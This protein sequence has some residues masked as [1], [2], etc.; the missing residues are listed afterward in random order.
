MARPHKQTVDYFPHF[1]NSKKTLL[2]MESRWG[3][4]G[5]AFWFKM[6]EMLCS[7]EGH[8]IDADN[9]ADLEYIIGRCRITEDA[10]IE[11]LDVLARVGAI[12][13]ELWAD[14]RLIWCQNLVDNLSDLYRKRT[15]PAPS[16]PSF[17]R[18]KP[19]DC[20]ISDADKTPET[21]KV[22]ESKPKES[23]S[24]KSKAATEVFGV[25]LPGWKMERKA[26]EVWGVNL[27]ARFPVFASNLA[28]EME[29]FINY[30]AGKTDHK[31]IWKN[32]L[33]NWATKTKDPTF[34]PAPKPGAKRPGAVPSAADL[35][36]QE[37]REKCR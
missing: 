14:S 11:M 37:R 25:I 3:N 28:A 20:G 26:D 17:R 1:V 8:V 4:I 10:A 6:L 2:A 9:P 33:L 5:Y 31:G 27:L 36:E 34:C 29:K 16:R 18:R 12:D 35:D 21:R 13:S 19:S 24:N 22:K 23:K 30:H 7:S 32:R 15:C